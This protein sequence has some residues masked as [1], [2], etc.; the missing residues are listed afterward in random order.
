MRTEG[1]VAGGEWSR[2]IFL[3]PHPDDEF[4]VYAELEASRAA[5]RPALCIFLTDGAAAGQSPKRRNAESTAVLTKLG[6]GGSDIAFLGCQLG[7]P[8][9]SLAKHLHR[10]KA[11][12]EAIIGAVTPCDRLY[13]PAW[14]GGHQD[15]DAAHLLGLSIAGERRSVAFQFPLYQGAGL[16]WKLFRVL[17]PLR[18]NGPVVVRRIAW[19]SR[20]AY[21]RYCLS[22]PSQW[23][24]W[25]GLLPF[26]LV[27]YVKSGSQKLQNANPDRVREPPHAGRLLYERRG[28]CT[29]REFEAST[30]AFR[31]TLPC[32]PAIPAA[33]GRQ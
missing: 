29:W 30:R 33:P 28:F 13:M 32:G 15:H 21:L 26:V 24:T 12:V 6:V 10:V 8:D 19:R 27:D 14:E 4:G 23:K 25:L 1:D 16:P 22:Y 7:V 2:S 5:G 18:Q 3:L 31:S 20:V 11:G 17:T 9:G